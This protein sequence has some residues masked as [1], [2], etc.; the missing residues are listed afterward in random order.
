MKDKDMVRGY[1]KQ[2]IASTAYFGFTENINIKQMVQVYRRV[3]KTPADVPT[4]ELLNFLVTLAISNTYYKDFDDK[5][6]KFVEHAIN[7]IEEQFTGTRNVMVKRPS[8]STTSGS[9]GGGTEEDLK[10]IYFKQITTDNKSYD[11][12]AVLKPPT[13]QILDDDVTDVAAVKGALAD[14]SVSESDTSPEEDEASESEAE[15]E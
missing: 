14:A 11:K 3:H 7:I 4:D 15:A 10:L 1:L 6:A 13:E 5:S 2:F 12:Q 8:D 9:A